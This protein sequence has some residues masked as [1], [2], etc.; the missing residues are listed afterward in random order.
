MNRPDLAAERLGE[1]REWLGKRERSLQ[2]E[3]GW[4]GVGS[5]C[6]RQTWNVLHGVPKVND[7]QR[8]LAGMRG[9]AV[10]EFLAPFFAERGWQIETEVEWGGIPGSVDLLRDGVVEDIKTGSADKVRSL[11]LYGPTR[12]WRW[13]VQGYA[14][15]LAEKGHDVRTVR[16]VAYAYD[17]SEEVAAWEEP[18]LPEVSD[19]ALAHVAELADREDAPA[20]GKDADFCRNW[21][22]FFDETMSKGGCPSRTLG[23]RLV[24]LEDPV[25]RQ[26]AVALRQARDEA[27]AATERK[28]AAESVLDGASGLVDGYAVT[29]VTVAPSEVPD[30]EAIREAHRFVIGELP[31]REKAGYSYVSVRKARAAK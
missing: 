4:S 27:K 1:L 11:A 13:Q 6:D 31:T 30:D 16:I 22:S 18:Y 8:V 26:A 5:D 12:G 25:L 15:A 23:S 10:H 20:P 9:I 3:L 28:K 14:R 2:T 7:R 17:S 21:C 29:Q 19:E 24:E